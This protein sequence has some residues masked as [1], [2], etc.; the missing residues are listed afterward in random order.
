MPKP[1]L[2]KKILVYLTVIHPTFKVLL[3]S[4]KY[5]RNEILSLETSKTS[6][7]YDIKLEQQKPLL[8]NDDLLPEGKLELTMLVSHYNS[9]NWLEAFAFLKIWQNLDFEPR[10]RT[11]LQLHIHMF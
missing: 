4:S 7:L 11:K 5:C 10:N 3:S 2:A 6:I 9:H 8:E 1:I